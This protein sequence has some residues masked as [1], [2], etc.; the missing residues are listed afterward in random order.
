MKASHLTE[1]AEEIISTPAP[2]GNLPLGKRVRAGVSWTVSSS[3]IGEL[4]RFFRSLILARILIPEDFGLLGMALTIVAALNAVTAL[5]LDRTIVSHQF[6]TR[7]QLKTHLDTIWTAE[8]IR[9]LVIALLVSASAFPIARFYGQPQLAGIVPMLGLVSLIQGFQNIGLVLLRKEISFAKIFWY[10]LGTNAAGFL[11]TI[12]L[13]LV[14]RNVWALALGLLVTAVIGVVLSYIL[15]PYRPRPALETNALHRAW[16]LGKFGLVFAVASFVTNMADNVMVGRLLGS[17]ALGNYSLAYNISSTPIQVLV[18]ALAA[19]FF[20]AYAEI[21]LE[22]P[23]HPEQAFVKVFGLSLLALMTIASTFFLLGNEIV[24][25]LF[26]NRWTSAGVVLPVLALIIPLRGFTLLATPL[27]FAVNQPKYLAVGRSL[28]ALVFLAALYP[29][30]EVFGLSGVAWAGLIAYT[31]ASV[32]RLIALQKIIPGV[33]PKLFRIALSNV[34]TAAV[35]LLVA[36]VSLS[37]IT[38]PLARLLVG[39]ILVMTIP[40]LIMLAIRADFRKWVLEWLS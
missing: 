23:K 31:F 30:I 14:L 38:L 16:N 4:I 3:L 8:L 2:P 21:K 5:G 19:V 9:S 20:P 24:R 26:G 28:E 22:R 37:Y 7:A 27:L 36:G 25:L 34:G 1:P 10:E 32:N 18:A 15:H 6:D 11:I 17:A 12:A 13:A 33:S 29:L 39:G 35:G 40:A